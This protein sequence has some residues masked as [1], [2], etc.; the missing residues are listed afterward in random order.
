VVRY[1]FAYTG[2]VQECSQIYF[3]SY[4]SSRF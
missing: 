4:S 2:S 3:V 1:V